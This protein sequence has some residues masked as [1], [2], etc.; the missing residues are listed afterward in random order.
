MATSEGNAVCA[1]QHYSVAALMALSRAVDCKDVTIIYRKG[2][3]I[4]GLSTDLVC[5][6]AAL[7]I[8]NHAAAYVHI[9]AQDGFVPY[10][11]GKVEFRATRPVKPLSVISVCVKH[12]PF[13]IVLG[14]NEYVLH[15]PRSQVSQMN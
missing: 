9:L 6:L 12:L 15:N 8:K 5:K 2:R 1:T 7:K 11:N 14:V 13:E 4:C 10:R 3:I